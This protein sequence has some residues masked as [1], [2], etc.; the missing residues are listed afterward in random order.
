MN[1]K[2]QF[3]F[4]SMQDF[5]RELRPYL[6]ARAEDSYEIYQKTSKLDI[7]TEV[8]RE[9]ENR[10]F[11]F[12]HKIAPGDGLIGEESTYIENSVE[13]IKKN[14]WYV[15]PIDGTINFVCQK[16]NFCISVAYY[17]EG[18]GKVAWI[19]DV[20][21]D[22]M[23]GAIQGQGAYLNAKIILPPKDR[24]LEESFMGIAA[25]TL[26]YLEENETAV[27]KD[28][29]Y[30]AL[31]FRAYGVSTLQMMYVATGQLGGYMSKH[32]CPWDYAAGI[33]ILEELGIEVSDF[34][35]Q[36]LSLKQG[37]A[38]TFICATK[39]IYHQLLKV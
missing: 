1:D 24:P 25:R 26:Q 34:H 16:K 28:R 29:I 27:R 30:H 12:I 22:K 39:K 3:Y 6:L 20:Y 33:I 36:D 9:I 11:A 2:Y 10:I 37:S 4:L 32:L 19:Y 38:S 17:E 8:D 31:G 5:L 21:R 18:V 13:K 35:F 14:M 23:Y 15:D 7:V